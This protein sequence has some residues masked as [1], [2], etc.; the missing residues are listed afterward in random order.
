MFGKSNRRQPT[1]PAH[2][3]RPF[4]SDNAR[5]YALDDFH[6]AYFQQALTG[7]RFLYALD[8]TQPPYGLNYTV[9]IHGLGGSLR[10]VST[11]QPLLYRPDILKSFLE[12]QP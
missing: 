1:G 7:E 3:F 2:D 6:L 10:P 12:D 9:P 5:E 8:A 11:P 4:Q